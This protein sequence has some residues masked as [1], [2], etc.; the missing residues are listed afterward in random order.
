MCN[1]ALNGGGGLDVYWGDP[2]THMNVLLYI[3]QRML[4]WNIWE[5]VLVGYM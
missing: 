4:K 3:G 2:K 1:E 5:T